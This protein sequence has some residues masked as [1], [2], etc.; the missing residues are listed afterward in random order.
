MYQLL[1]GAATCDFG[2]TPK[3]QLTI[4]PGQGHVSVMMHTQTIFGYL[5]SYLK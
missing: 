5:N 2:V 3:S 1:G 4:I